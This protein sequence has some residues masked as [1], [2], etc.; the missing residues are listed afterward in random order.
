MKNQTLTTE[1]N[2][3]MRKAQ[4]LG[5]ATRGD[6]FNMNPADIEINWE[7]NPRKDYGT[8]DEQNELKESIRLNGIML[9]IHVYS[10]GSKFKLGHGFRRMKAVTELLAEGLDIRVPVIKIETN[11]E[12]ILLAHFTLNTGKPLTDLEIGE[13]LNRLCKLLGEDNFTNISKRSGIEYQKVVRLVN[14]VR[15]ASTQVKTAIANDEMS[16]TT[17]IEL[18]AVT[19][20][21]AEQNEVLAELKETAEVT[22]SGK[23][24]LTVKAV[25]NAT[26][27]TATT[28]KAKKVTANSDS[29]TYLW[30][31][32]EQAEST[33]LNTKMQKLL[34]KVEEGLSTEELVGFVNS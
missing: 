8:E 30:T 16:V 21:V 7:E 4:E 2:I 27:K 28:P 20:G 18:V 32:L 1:K 25:Q 10:V 23:K 17:A 26:K 11:E 22:K 14:L 13:T 6:S 9:P 19:S 15:N 31:I 24:K 5:L 12:A 33:E 3:T 34:M 29:Y